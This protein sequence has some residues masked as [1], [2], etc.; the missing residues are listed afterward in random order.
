MSSFK[1]I[2][3]ALLSYGMSG[4]V[5]HAR[6]PCCPSGL[7]AQNSA[8]KEV[9]LSQTILPIY[10]CGEAFTHAVTSHSKLLPQHKRRNNIFTQ[11]PGCDSLESGTNIACMGCLR[12]SPKQ[13][14]NSNDIT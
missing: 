5:F 14:L 1:P 12:Y 13:V 4:E 3:T 9:A 6:L 8:P 2:T 7:Q 10:Y 11:R